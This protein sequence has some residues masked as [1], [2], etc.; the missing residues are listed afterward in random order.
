[1]SN[2]QNIDPPKWA[3]SLVRRYVK[4]HLLERVEGDLYEL[5]EDRIE[6]SGPFKA[7]WSFVLDSIRLL[8]PATSNYIQFNQFVMLSNYFK[9]S[10]RNLKR[11]YIP[12]F[13]NI[14]GLSVAIGAC[15]TLFLFLNFAMTANNYHEH[16]EQIFQV[17]NFLTRSGK[18][19]F[20]SGNSPE[21]LGPALKDQFPQIESFTRY[22]R[23]AATFK[24]KDK[25]FNDQFQIVDPAFLDMFTFPLRLGDKSLL[26]QPNSIIL[27]H[28]M[29]EKYFGDGDPI[30]ESME[31]ILPSGEKLGFIVNGV[32][33]KFPTNT[34]F[35]FNALVS[36]QNAPAIL[37]RDSNSWA[38]FVNATFIKLRNPGDAEAILAG[39]KPF[40][41]LQNQSREN[42]QIE[43]FL[44]E[45][46]QTLSASAQG[47]SG[48]VVGGE[49]K[50]TKIGVVIIG[51]LL[52]LLAC[53][54]YINIAIVSSTRRIKEIGVRKSIGGSK[55]QLVFQFL[56]ENIIICAFS[57]VLGVALGANLFL[58]LLNGLMPINLGSDLGNPT[59]WLFLLGILLFTGV[60][61][62]AYP[63]F[64]ISA[65]NAVN[66]FQGRVKLGSGKGYLFK[67]FLTFQFMLSF[68]VAFASI[69]FIQNSKYQRQIDWGYNQSQVIA[70]YL[71]DN[72]YEQFRNEVASLSET[73]EVVGSVNHVGRSRR[74][75]NF[76]L[77]GEPKECLQFQV[78]FGY[79]EIMEFDLLQGRLFEQSRTSDSDRAVVVN[80][81]FVNDFAIESPVGKFIKVDTVEMEIIGVVKDFHYQSFYSSIEPV[82]FRVGQEEDFNYLVARIG[83]GN[84]VQ[85]GEKMQNL[86][87]RLNP[88]FPYEGFF[89]DQTFDDF[90][91]QMSR[92]TRL[93]IG[94]AFLS[95]ILSAMGLFGL[96]SLLIAQ[97][98]KEFS[99]R[100]VLGA[101][102]SNVIYMV[103]KPFLLVMVIALILSGPLSFLLI[104]FYLDTIHSFHIPIGI[105]QI[106]L[107]MILMIAVGVI[108]VSTQV[109][110]V[111]RS[112][113]VQSLREE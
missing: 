44:L 112:N 5:F 109:L 62:G 73:E 67:T 111:V 77:D 56:T 98:M 55:S 15:Y 85:A 97:K 101:A 86:W 7:R 80:E 41:D 1:M 90:F 4:P 8:R 37:G 79:S 27:S 43:D 92:P 93:L 40:I 50:S 2:S 87:A 64:Y 14:F 99:I 75:F 39:M 53:F 72:S 19:S 103:N 38:N 6:R 48:R 20:L 23:S 60:V 83:A 66:I 94:V 78:G 76:S 82:V 18:S 110:K 28:A 31:A 100:K 47:L 9:L 89:Q 29:A 25:V 42:R 3:I 21:P 58:P 74:G 69:V 59:I 105:I 104:D 34:T 106:S 10:L 49:A 17:E 24:Y 107:A 13:I 54:N 91:V 35:L 96:V 45:N 88:D 12:S 68:L 36:Y 61:S 46:F 84:V 95:I 81:K 63:A 52:L 113:P 11:N 16:K 65:F 33:E 71:Q 57:V 26:A 32:A 102:V 22:N 70:V 108:T 30:G 51:A